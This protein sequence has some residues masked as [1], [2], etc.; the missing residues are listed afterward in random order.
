MHLRLPDIPDP[1]LSEFLHLLR[2]ENLNDIVVLGGA[3]RDTLISRPCQDID[4]AIRLKANAPKRIQ[5]SDSNTAYKMI[6]ALKSSLFPLAKALGHETPVFYNPVPFGAVVVDV[7][8]LMP[9]KDINGQIYPDIFIDANQR[10]FNARPELSVNQLALDSEGK[11][12]PISAIHDLNNRTARFTEAPLGVHLR[13]VLRAIWTC[14]RLELMLIP[15]SAKKMI[16]HLQTLENPRFFEKEFV[17]QDTQKFLCE[18]I[19]EN[20]AKNAASN[21][22]TILARIASLIRTYSN[23]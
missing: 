5:E 16:L 21:I 20:A 17:E 10:V 18:L 6:P 23:A 4:I 7:L 12:W 9:V 19:D 22:S 2:K 8:G 15:E 13:Q 1:N 3:V 14:K 11:V